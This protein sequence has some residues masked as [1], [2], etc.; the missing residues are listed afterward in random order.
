SDLAGGIVSDDAMSPGRIIRSFQDSMHDLPVEFQTKLVIY[1]LFDRMVLS[2][3]TDLFTGA[4][5]LLEGH[6]VV[7]RGLEAARP[8]FRDVPAP[9]PIDAGQAP[10]R[11]A[12]PLA[13][14]TLASFGYAPAPA[15]TSAADAGYGSTVHS[16]SPPARW[17][18]AGGQAHG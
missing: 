18:T 1:N 3:L 5:Q 2:R 9:S 13:P 4:N 14:A 7:P 10:P 8:K 15:P 16:G 11:W 6:G 17:S 12:T